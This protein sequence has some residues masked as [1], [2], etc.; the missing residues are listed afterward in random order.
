MFSR[1][2]VQISESLIRFFIMH[3]RKSQLFFNNSLSAKRYVLESNNIYDNNIRCFA[4]RTIVF[5]ESNVKW[6]NGDV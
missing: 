4:G 1:G 6:N 3:V 2:F 5:I